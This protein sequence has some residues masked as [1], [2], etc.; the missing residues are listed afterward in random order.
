MSGQ[1]I[2]ED[3][4]ALYDRQIRLWGLDAQKR[5]RAS[6]ILVISANGL[7]GEVMKNIVL[8]GINSLTL[9]DSTL[10]SEEHLSAMFLVNSSHIG[11]NLAEASLDAIRQLN[12]LVNVSADVSNAM[13]KPVEYFKRFDIVCMSS[14]NL[15]DITRIDSICSDN[16]V[17]FLCGSV[18][19][20]YGFMFSNLGYHEYAEEI[21]V[22]KKAESAEGPGEPKRAKLSEVKI[23]TE[24]HTVRRSCQFERFKSSLAVDWSK[25]SMKQLRKV[26][27]IYFIIRSLLDFSTLNGHKPSIED[28]SA[29]LEQ[30]RATMDSFHLPSSLLTDHFTVSNACCPELSP[31]CAIVGG[32]LAQ[33]ILKAVSHKDAPHNNHFLFDPESLAGIVECIHSSAFL[34]KKASS[35]KVTEELLL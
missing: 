24:T 10:V 33:E 17:K 31:V 25:L 23:E 4:A 18:F 32:V 29:V 26:S 20:F 15:D 3:E 13:E 1:T 6:N 21:K 11:Q 14:T 34:P 19:G 8:A 35:E 28:A 16:R 7:T 5:M 27:H 22:E 9:L 30:C 2:T 12:P